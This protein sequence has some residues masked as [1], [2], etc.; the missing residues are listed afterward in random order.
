MVPKRPGLIQVWLDPALSSGIS[1]SPSL[2]STFIPSQTF[3]IWWQKWPV[4]APG[5]CS[6]SLAIPVEKG[7]FFPYSSS[8]NLRACL[9]WSTL[10]HVPI[11]EP[12]GHHTL[13]DQRWIIGPP[14]GTRFGCPLIWVTQID[15]ER[16]MVSQ[17]KIGVLLLKKRR[18]K[19]WTG[20]K[21]E[22]STPGVHCSVS[23][24]PKQTPGI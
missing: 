5:F 18:D 22:I 12:M 20:K 6:T 21:Q 15:T 11:P 2:S 8:K 3:A 19:C 14:L 10:G 16:R 1:P 9:H 4:A 23:L 7:C 24:R 17:R 13:I